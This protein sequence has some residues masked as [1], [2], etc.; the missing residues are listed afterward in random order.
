MT[1][2]RKASD[3]FLKIA[4]MDRTIAPYLE[5]TIIEDS[6]KL[7]NATKEPV[8]ELFRTWRDELSVGRDGPGADHS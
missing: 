5:W 4:K 6:D 1:C 7:D 3:D 2:W 8:R